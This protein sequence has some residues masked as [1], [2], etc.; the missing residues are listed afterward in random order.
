MKNQDDQETY[1]NHAPR[2]AESFKMPRCSHQNDI[3]SSDCRNISS[4]LN[5]VLM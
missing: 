3:A 1:N 2:P 4:D 5:L